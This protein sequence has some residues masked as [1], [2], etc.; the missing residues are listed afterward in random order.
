M[1]SMSRKS[2]GRAGKALVETQLMA[3]QEK[4]HEGKN[5]RMGPRS[6]CMPKGW[7]VSS[8]CTGVTWAAGGSCHLLF[9]WSPPCMYYGA[10]GF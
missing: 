8:L 1:V 4:E 5:S 7:S 9:L 2:I 10:L 6:G 3:A